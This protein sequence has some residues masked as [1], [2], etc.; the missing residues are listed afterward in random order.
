M[1]KRFKFKRFFFITLQ[2]LHKRIVGLNWDTD[3]IERI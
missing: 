2:I 3:D 1:L